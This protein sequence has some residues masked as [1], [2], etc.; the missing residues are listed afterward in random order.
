MVTQIV[1][2]LL[3]VCLAIASVRSLLRKAYLRASIAIALL[4]LLVLALMAISP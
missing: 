4:L 1:L 3:I 2:G